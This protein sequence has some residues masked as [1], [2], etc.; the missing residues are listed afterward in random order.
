MPTLAKEITSI[1]PNE[2]DLF[3]D[4]AQNLLAVLSKFVR[5]PDFVVSVIRRFLNASRC[6]AFTT[7][8]AGT[9]A[10]LRRNSRAAQT[11]SDQR[12][13]RLPRGCLSVDVW[14]MQTCD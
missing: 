6:S 1:A 3:L 5:F 8:G 11:D 9:G 7:C 13:I 10:L 12:V 14:G 4:S 2:P